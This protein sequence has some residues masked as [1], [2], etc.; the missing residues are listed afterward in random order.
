MFL[1]LLAVFLVLW[2]WGMST[3]NH[4]YELYALVAQVV[5]LSIMWFVYL[6][7]AARAVAGAL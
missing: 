6:Q 2:S 3:T 5:T 4:R 1:V 7:P